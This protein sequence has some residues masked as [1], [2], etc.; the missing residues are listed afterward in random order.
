MLE[1]L[2][3]MNAPVWQYEARTADVHQHNETNVMH[4][5]RNL[6]RINGLYIFQAL[7]AHPQEMPHKWHLIYCVRVMSISCT[8]T[9]VPLQC[10][11]S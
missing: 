10:W 6:L 9:G 3:S 8:R 1:L 4:F 7:L 5:L 2:E 11:C